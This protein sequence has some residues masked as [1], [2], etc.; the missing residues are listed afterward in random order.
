MDIDNL[1]AIVNMIAN[2]VI[3]I[4]LGAFF[5]LL[6]G[7]E[8]SIVHKWPVITHWSVKIGLITAVVASMYNLLNAIVREVMPRHF[9]DGSIILD[10][11]HTPPGEVLLNVG[12]AILFAWVFYFH[13]FHFLKVMGNFKKT[14]RSRT[15]PKTKIKPKTRAGTNVRSKLPTRNRN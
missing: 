1:L 5:I 6:Y 8:N 10:F 14:S 3:G 2:S 4:S 7:N 11:T 12:L 13:K 9:D 15:A